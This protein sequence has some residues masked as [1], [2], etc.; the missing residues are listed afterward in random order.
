MGLSVATGAKA[1][2]HKV[3]TMNRGNVYWGA[4]ATDDVLW[5]FLD[6]EDRKSVRA[7]A[8]FIV[9][10]ALRCGP[11]TIVDFSCD[12]AK[13]MKFFLDCLCARV[14][15]ETSSV[16]SIGHYVLVSSDSVYQNE[17]GSSGPWGTALVDETRPTVAAIAET[18]RRSVRRSYAVQK[19]LIEVE[20]L[21]SARRLDCRRTV[22][23]LPDVIGPRDPTGRF[24]ATWLWAASGHPLWFPGPEAGQQP[25]SV[26]FSEDVAAWLLAVIAQGSAW[27]GGTYNLACSEVP[28]LAELTLLVARSAR[29]GALLLVPTE[30]DGD[31]E[32]CDF[33][34]SVT[35]G[36]LS[37]A[38]ALAESP[39]RPTPLVECIAATA[40]FFREPRGKELV[41][42]LRKLPGAV[43]KQV[44]RLFCRGEW[45]RKAPE[46]RRGNVGEE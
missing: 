34:P 3:I 13:Q 6:W 38:R 28:S 37:I 5:H 9:S 19:A 2:G 26:V 20:L 10:T 31:K 7:A 17:P 1:A 12:K 15:G 14:D 32:T 39:W 23:R 21:S 18:C 8:A 29:S 25:V 45:D 41:A 4:A 27:S 35:C 16:A 24:W 40:A 33:Y 22:V 44:D 30:S 36:P 43:V 46:G 42:V 11:P